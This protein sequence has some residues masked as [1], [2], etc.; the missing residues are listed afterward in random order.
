MKTWTM[1][2]LREA[3]AFLAN[4]PGGTLVFVNLEGDEGCQRRG[5]TAMDFNSGGG[6]RSPEG[7]WLPTVEID[8][9]GDS[10]NGHWTRATPEPCADLSRKDEGK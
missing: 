8:A 2:Q 3:V 1:A 4:V 10:G 7:A 9:D 6:R 5:L